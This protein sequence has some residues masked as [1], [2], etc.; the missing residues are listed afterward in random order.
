VNRA[1]CFVFLTASLAV[2]AKPAKK[3]LPK[4][5]AVVDAG[6]PVADAG[7]RATDAGVRATDAGTVSLDAGARVIDA[8]IA[9][10]APPPKP[11]PTKLTLVVEEVMFHSKTPVSS[12]DGKTQSMSGSADG[13]TVTLRVPLDS[14]DTGIG[15]RNGHMRDYLEA[16]TWPA[17]E[18]KVGRAL[19]K[20]GA[21][22]QGPGTFTVHGVSREVKVTFDVTK[23][24][25]GLK[26]KGGFP[27]NLKDYGIK[28]PTYLGITVKPDVTVSADF[29]V[30]N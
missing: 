1:L 3:S 28:I 13:D 10:T 5:P 22:Q 6:V 4:K 25:D 29:V 12:I 7:V 26:V 30:K 23:T 24:T 27:I 18:L 21:Q 2:A 17:A 19:L 8:G 14:V 11:A 9:V 15:L 20:E 16:T